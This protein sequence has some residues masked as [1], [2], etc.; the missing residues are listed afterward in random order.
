MASH[1]GAGDVGLFAPATLQQRPA[2]QRTETVELKKSPKNGKLNTK[3]GTKLSKPTPLGAKTGEGAGRY[4]GRPDDMHMAAWIIQLVIYFIE[5]GLGA[6]FAIY[7]VVNIPPT[8]PYNLVFSYFYPFWNYSAKLYNAIAAFAFVAMFHGFFSFIA[9]LI[10]PVRMLIENN[11]N[12]NGIDFFN[13]A[14][15]A[16]ILPAI[17]II[18]MQIEGKTDIDF[19]VLTVVLSII[20]VF[21]YYKHEQVN[22][23]YH[24]MLRNMD[25]GYHGERQ[26]SAEELGVTS[27]RADWSFYGMA[28]L[29]WLTFFAF[30]WA[31]FAGTV[32][33][34]TTSTARFWVYISVALVFTVIPLIM[35]ILYGVRYAN[36]S[37]YGIHRL[38]KSNWWTTIN[39]VLLTFLL[40]NYLMIAMFVPAVLIY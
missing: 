21:F 28:L 2:T 31:V 24:R 10:R 17:V 12:R 6:S 32:L 29:V 27:D 18:S 20:L 4:F 7:S 16:M 11:I 15:R 22:M 34:N 9:L 30:L 25:R 8:H 26:L 35:H 38:R 40:T 23:A 19:I 37:R 13:V 33:L 14:M 3:K 5:F 39:A 36:T 1:S